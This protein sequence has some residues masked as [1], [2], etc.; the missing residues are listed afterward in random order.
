MPRA[1]G[2]KQYI[3]LTQ[4]LITEASPLAAPEGSTSD[5]LNMDLQLNGMIRRR[6]L[7]LQKQI[8]DLN[9]LGRITGSWY[10]P[11]AGYTVITTF[12]DTG[13]TGYDTVTL[14][15]LDSSDFSI[16]DF[17]RAE[18][19]E[20]NGVS[21]DFSELRN[22]LI[23]TFGGAPMV[24]SKEVD[25]T[26]SAWYVDLFIR[27]F[28]FVDDSMTVS[29]RPSTLTSEHQ[30][31]ILNAGWYQKV[32][33][34]GGAEK[35]AYV[36]F[37][38]E[39]SNYPSNADIVSLGIGA[40]SSGNTIFIPVNMKTPLTGNTEA[41]RGHYV[42]N[43]R[44]INRLS[45]LSSPQAD[46]TPSKTITQVLSSGT[47]ISGLGSN[48]IYKESAPTGTPVDPPPLGPGDGFIIP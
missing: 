10:W 32:I 24:F 5:E 15:F 37:F 18:I 31:N 33:L 45:K 22:R 41:P 47:N 39:L 17:Y 6:R 48:L 2:N 8:A 3:A 38:D 11:A 20:G 16:V 36:A 44:S 1:R 13:S 28:K 9:M 23:V 4:G 26:L 42:Y 19:L 14:Y 12:S 34:E 46:G 29:N 21:P 7:G 43:V 27:D 40:D 25:G 30:Y 35:L